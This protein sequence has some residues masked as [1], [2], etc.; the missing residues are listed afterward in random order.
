MITDGDIMISTSGEKVGQINGL[1]IMMNGDL[2][3]GHAVRVTA[4]TFIGKSGV[5]N[6]EREVSMSGNTHSKVYIFYLHIL[7]K[8]CS[9]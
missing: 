3:F 1:T 5:I 8:I 9:R 2:S 7:V 6:I 4:N